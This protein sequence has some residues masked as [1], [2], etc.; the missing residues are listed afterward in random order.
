MYDGRQYMCENRQYM[1]AL[2]TSQAIRYGLFTYDTDTICNYVQMASPYCATVCFPHYTLQC[3]A[4]C[5]YVN[6]FII[7]LSEVIS[8][9]NSKIKLGI[10]LN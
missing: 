2:S 8:Q 5:N 7:R 3:K 9:Q 4:V 1:C 6:A 10:Q